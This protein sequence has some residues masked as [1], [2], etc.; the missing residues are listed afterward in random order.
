MRVGRLELTALQSSKQPPR[1][2]AA[3]VVPALNI[4]VCLHRVLIW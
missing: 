1:K 2:V 4:K 3:R